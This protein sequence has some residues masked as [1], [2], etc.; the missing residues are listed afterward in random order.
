MPS[1]KRPM[2]GVPQMGK[3][4]KKI[5]STLKKPGKNIR[6]LD[7]ARAGRPPKKPTYKLLGNPKKTTYK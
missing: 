3:A 1:P 4:P 6:I 7:P 5:P 2:G